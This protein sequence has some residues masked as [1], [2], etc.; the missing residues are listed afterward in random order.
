MLFRSQNHLNHAPPPPPSTEPPQPRPTSPSLAPYL[1]PPATRYHDQPPTAPPPPHPPPQLWPPAVPDPSA[2]GT[3]SASRAL[4]AP[5]PA[6][7][8]PYDH[9][10]L[11][12]AWDSADSPPHRRAPP[13]PR[14]GRIRQ[15][16]CNASHGRC[17]AERCPA[18]PL[19]LLHRAAAASSIDRPPRP[20]PLLL[21]L[22]GL[23]HRHR[24]TPQPQRATSPQRW[25]GSD[26]HIV[27][28][29]GVLD[30]ASPCGPRLL[31]RYGVQV[32]GSLVV[33]QPRAP[34][35]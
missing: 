11:A 15:D 22:A 29:V 1:P 18:L 6:F 9:I 23:V 5:D 2:A 25:M 16:P 13:S 3:K 20:W 32:T 14:A 24:C 8:A 7:P 26:G 12:G 34:P 27:Q 28:L 21:D 33:E 30:R 17:V 10:R 31:D 35:T 19:H 4:P